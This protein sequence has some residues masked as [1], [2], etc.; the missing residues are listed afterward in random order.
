LKGDYL[1]QISPKRRETIFS[2]ISAG[3]FFIVIGAIFA[4][5]SFIEDVPLFDKIIDF[6]RPRNWEL[7]E[8]FPNIR[9]VMLPRPIS[10]G[11]TQRAIYGAVTRFNIVWSF[12]QAAILIL[13]MFA[14]SP[15]SK[16]AET[17]SNIVSSL[18]T[19]YITYILIE[20]TPVNSAMWFGFWAQIIMILGLSLLARSIILAFRS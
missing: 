1:T 7:K 15:I 19:A 10:S 13:R 16:K 4:Y 6:V 18:G 12:C 3:L 8:V 14:R 20:N 2:V 11:A 17:V 9:F 5:A